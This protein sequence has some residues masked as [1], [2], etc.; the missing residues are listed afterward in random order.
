M[1]T[2]KMRIDL[3]ASAEDEVN[4]RKAA[5]KLGTTKVSQAI[6][7]S[8][9]Q[10]AD[11]KP[12]LFFCNR[13]AIRDLNSNLRAGQLMLQD[14]VNELTAAVPGIVVSMTD[15]SQ[16]FGS[17]RSNFMVADPRAIREFVISELLAAQRV[18]YPDLQINHDNIIV[19]DLSPVL[20]AASK[21]ITVPA[22]NY[23]ELGII[24]DA[25]AIT[26]G[27]VTVIPERA[28]EAKN[29]F[30]CYAETPEERQ[31][32]AKVRALCESLD[33]FAKGETFNP[34]R[35]NIPDVCHYDTESGRFEPS[36]LY[37]KFSLK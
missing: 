30:R 22:V 11:Q 15:I 37:V 26:D 12:D 36:E 2:K 33:G 32:L 3:K 31:R 8:V 25:Y 34:A 20:E 27:T 1:V 17:Y 24:W 18:K 13:S 19:P 5:A 28:E 21:L 35:L 16:W 9:K 7:A 23:R 29:L 6:M 4:L 14:L 10:V